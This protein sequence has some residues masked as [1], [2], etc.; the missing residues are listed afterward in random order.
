MT[1]P[2]TAGRFAST[3]GFRSLRVADE[4]SQ[5]RELIFDG[6]WRLVA[7][8]NEYL[9]LRQGGSPRTARTYLA[10]LRPFVGFLIDRGYAWNDEPDRVRQYV[11]EYLLESG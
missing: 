4:T 10:V 5:Y 9:R 11:R 8:L 6:Q 7:Q 2:R 1:P 3:V